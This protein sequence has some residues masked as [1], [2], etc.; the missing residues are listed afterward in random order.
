[1]ARACSGEQQTGN[2]GARLGH[3]YVSTRGA[4]Q[5]RNIDSC[6]E[7][8]RWAEGRNKCAAGHAPEREQG[9]Q[10][11]GGGDAE[12]PPDVLVVREVEDDVG[13]EGQRPEDHE[14]DKGDEAVLPRRRVLVRHH[15]AELLRGGERGCMMDDGSRA[16]GSFISRA[17]RGHASA[18][19]NAA[20]P[21]LST[22]LPV[23]LS[24]QCASLPVLPVYLSVTTRLHHHVVDEVVVVLALARE[25]PDHGGGLL[26]VESLGHVDLRGIS[27]KCKEQRSSDKSADAGVGP[28][29]P[30]QTAAP[31][32]ATIT[33]STSGSQIGAR[34]RICC[35]T[36]SIS[37]ISPSG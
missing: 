9:Q 13:D 22:L 16:R 32:E 28:N 24:Q 23:R 3:K 12:L 11:D 10:C 8:K 37:L 21:P 14:G 25:G 15:L 6:G 18:S 1:M 35:R 19:P 30:V 7:A 29:A 20:R 27:P 2:R 4:P 5:R 31:S 36:S 26:L 17:D 34:L 33:N